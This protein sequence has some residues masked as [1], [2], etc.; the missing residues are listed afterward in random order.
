MAFIAFMNT[1]EELET[2]MLTEGGVC[3]KL[4][5]SEEYTAKAQENALMYE[6]VNAVNAD[7]II[8]PAVCDC[9]PSSIANTE[10][11]NLL[12]L[13]IDGTYTPEQFCQQLT[14]LAEETRLD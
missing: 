1:P 11:G 7:T 13:L 4:T 3:Q 6:Y 8:C 10:F 14:T 5:V 9:M 2:Y 12:P